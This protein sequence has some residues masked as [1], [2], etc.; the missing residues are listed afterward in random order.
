MDSNK[1]II[2]IF[3]AFIALTPISLSQ[4]ADSLDESA[5]FASRELA[6]SVKQSNDT[7]VINAILR[8]K[9]DYSQKGEWGLNALEAAYYWGNKN[10]FKCVFDYILKQR[11]T[12]FVQRSEVL[13]LAIAWGDTSTM[14]RLF[15]LYGGKLTSQEKESVI[16]AFVDFSLLYD[17]SNKYRSPPGDEEYSFNETLDYDLLIAEKLI[18]Y[19]IDFNKPDKIGRNILFYCKHFSAVAKFFIEEKKIDLNLL[20]MEGKTFLQCYIDVIIAS[21]GVSYADMESYEREFG[22]YSKKIELLKYYI[23]AGAVVGSDYQNGW[24]YLKQKL[25]SGQNPF[26]LDFVKKRY[27]KYIK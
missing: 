3:W 22:F 7:G 27:N 15:S 10:A 16:N 6:I 20:D 18:Q 14:A 2:C 5:G 13:T 8:K 17:S 23:D 1:S 24:K 11:D 4:P 9:P 12:V 21:P 26:L 19:G 25:K